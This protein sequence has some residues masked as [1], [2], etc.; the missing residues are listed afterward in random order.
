MRLGN[1]ALTISLIQKAYELNQLDETHERASFG[2]YLR[3]TIN[4]DEPTASKRTV[5]SKFSF[6]FLSIK[7]RKFYFN[8]VYTRRG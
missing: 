5:S 2:A 1:R 8:P 7:K 4:K 6:V 3:K